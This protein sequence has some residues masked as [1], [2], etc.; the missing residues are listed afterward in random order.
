MKIENYQFPHSSFLSMDKDYGT[1]TQ[2]ILKNDRLKK[3]LYYST[4]DCLSKP[5]L[6]DDQSLSL[7]GKNIKIVPK[8][9]IDGEELCY[10]FITF[11]S[12]TPNA[13]NPQFRNNLIF[14]D[15]IC[16]LDAWQL[17]DFELRP[18]RIAAEI[19]TMFNKKHLSGIGELEFSG[20]QQVILTDE[21]AGL[22]LAYQAIHSEDDKKFAPNPETDKQLVDNFNK[23]FNNK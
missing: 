10:L 23:M 15:I 17:K 4:P 3:L 13:T 5:N 9:K 1:I 16:H 18:Y 19:D 14:F 8:L 11:D 12:F 6:T 2:W 21:F 7:F 20:C 22:V